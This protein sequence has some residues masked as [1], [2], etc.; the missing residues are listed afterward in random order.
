VTFGLVVCTTES[1][2]RI[3]SSKG[4]ETRGELENRQLFLLR[5]MG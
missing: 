1:V 4:H 5:G 2:V 3:R